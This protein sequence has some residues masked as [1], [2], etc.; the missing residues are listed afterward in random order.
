MRAQIPPLLSHICDP[1]QLAWEPFRE[2]IEIARI[3]ASE[4]GGP[5]AAYL[6]YR[7]G[8]TL[9]RHRHVGWE[10]ILILAGTQSDDFGIH[11][12]GELLVHIPGSSHTVHSADGCIV[13]AIWEKPVVFDQ[14]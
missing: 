1:T 6:R 11:A 4:C 3:L 2:G 12:A 10:Y 7:P 13:L 14:E 8:A 9:Q 5:A